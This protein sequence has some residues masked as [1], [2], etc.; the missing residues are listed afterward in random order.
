[1]YRFSSGETEELGA[2]NFFDENESDVFHRNEISRELPPGTVSS[3]VG[4]V[5]KEIWK[6]FIIAAFV[7]SMVE[8]MC[9]HR[10]IQ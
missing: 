9:F 2:V 5:S 6:W 3:S 10:K 8:W 1:M 4:S 7:V